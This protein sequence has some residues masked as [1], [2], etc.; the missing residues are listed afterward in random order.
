MS[1]RSELFVSNTTGEET[2]KRGIYNLSV[3]MFKKGYAIKKIISY[4]NEHYKDRFDKTCIQRFVYLSI[5]DFN[6]K[7]IAGN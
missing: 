7:E 4:C 3:M 2:A 1:V 5:M 6:N